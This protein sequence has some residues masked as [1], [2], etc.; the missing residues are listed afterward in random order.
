[1]TRL[2]YGLQSLVRESLTIFDLNL[3]TLIRYTKYNSTSKTP[4]PC[5]SFTHPCQESQSGKIHWR[6]EEGG[7]EEGRRGRVT[8]ASTNL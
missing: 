8:G 5:C 7:G 1:M 4:I 2:S 3:S 6:G